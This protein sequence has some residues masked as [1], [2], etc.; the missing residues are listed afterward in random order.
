MKENIIKIYLFNEEFKIKS[1]ETEEHIL[2]VASL[3]NAYLDKVQKKGVSENRLNLALLAALNISSEYVKIK[4]E[5]KN[6]EKEVMIRVDRLI[7]Q[8]D[9][10]LR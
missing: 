2:G 8:I 9:Q 10:H 7:K 5:Y 3:V 6:L 1:Q 4:G